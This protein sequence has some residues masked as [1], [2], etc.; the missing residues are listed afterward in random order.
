MQPMTQPPVA[1]AHRRRLQPLASALTAASVATAGEPH[2][3]LVAMRDLCMQHRLPVPRRRPPSTP[4][5]QLH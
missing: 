5:P 1:G 4:H 2:S 3:S